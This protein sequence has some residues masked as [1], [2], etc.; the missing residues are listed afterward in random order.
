M[1]PNIEED[2]WMEKKLWNVKELEFLVMSN[3]IRKKFIL[4]IALNAKKLIF[5]FWEARALG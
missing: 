5:E 3:H 2:E 4:I 1:A